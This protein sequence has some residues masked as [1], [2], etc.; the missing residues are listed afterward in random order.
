MA[1][2]NAERLR[3]TALNNA[4]ELLKVNRSFPA[5]QVKIHEQ[6]KAV[7]L[8]LSGQ[9]PDF[10]TEA[11]M[12]LALGIFDIRSNAYLELVTDMNSQE[13]FMAI[14]GEFA[15]KAWEQYTGI[16]MRYCPRT[17]W[18]SQPRSDQSKRG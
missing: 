1:R 8:N 17:L 6:T 12:E 11:R 14:L 4:I 13:A 15:R 18:R 10:R 7:M 3:R 9:E 2:R 16:H 5:A